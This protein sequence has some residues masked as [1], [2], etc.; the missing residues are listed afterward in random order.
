LPPSPAPPPPPAFDYPA[1]PAYPPPPAATAA[2]TIPST[3]TYASDPKQTSTR[4]DLTAID[5]QQSQVEEREK[6]LAEREKALQTA[7]AIGCKFADRQARSSRNEFII[8]ILSLAHD[9]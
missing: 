8:V 4:V 7:A 3:P 5:K 9:E 1:Y 2:A 6:T